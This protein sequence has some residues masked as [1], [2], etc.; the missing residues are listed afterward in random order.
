MDL[1]RFGHYTQSTK[2][3]CVAIMTTIEFSIFISTFDSPDYICCWFSLFFLDGIVCVSVFFI[4]LF[5]CFFFLRCWIFIC[6]SSAHHY[7]W[8]CFISVRMDM[9]KWDPE[10][11]IYS[12][13]AGSQYIYSWCSKFFFSLLFFFDSMHN[14]LCGWWRWQQ[15]RLRSRHSSIFV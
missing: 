3:E 7:S 13:D 1:F 12:T 4:V 5:C 8:F 2:S 15:Q 6:S 11:S 9:R 14:V 10:Q